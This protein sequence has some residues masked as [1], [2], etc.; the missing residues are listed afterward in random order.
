MAQK[1]Y[2]AAPR[3][4]VNAHTP[5]PGAP[6]FTGRVQSATAGNPAKEGTT[7]QDE[8]TP[9]R[10]AVSLPRPELS[11]RLGTR[12]YEA[13][14]LCSCPLSGPRAVFT[15]RSSSSGT[16]DAPPLLYCPAPAHLPRI[17]RRPPL[18]QPGYILGRRARPISQDEYRV[19]PLAARH[20]CGTSVSTNS[21]S[22]FLLDGYCPR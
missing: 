11:L 7:I 20:C 18:H 17:V 6:T 19:D 3:V 22:L 15:S 5:T 1:E 2:A 10:S 9:R 16:G 21:Q 12:P 8:R 13:S 14:L 4:P